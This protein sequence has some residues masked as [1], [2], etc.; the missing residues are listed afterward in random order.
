MDES[1]PQGNA[2]QKENVVKDTL[3]LFT[4]IGIGLFVIV[5]VIL[6]L[7]YFQII[8]L[9]RVSSLFSFIP[10]KRFVIANVNGESIF[11]DEVDH[12]IGLFTYFGKNKKSSEIKKDAIQFVI[13]RRLL[14][15]YV[16]E[17]NID[18]SSTV[19]K[20]Y[21]AS[22]FQY[23]NAA[24]LERVFN[25]DANTYKNYLTYNALQEKLSSSI[26]QWRIVD[27]L[28]VHYKWDESEGTKE[29]EEYKKTA[30]K[31]IKQYYSDLTSG[32]PIRTLVKQRCKDPEINYLPFQ[33]HYKLYEKTF[34]G[35]VCQ[36]QRVNF[37]VSKDTN[38]EWGNEWLEKVMRYHKGEI[39]QIITIDKPV[40]LY[41]L[42]KILDEGGNI[43][44]FDNL[45]STLKSKYNVSVLNYEYKNLY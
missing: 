30:L 12:A 1:A 38:P 28:S 16:Q 24:N 42:I 11:N 27:Y 23:T 44:S 13:N 8:N 39:S 37:T 29:G 7:N 36:E 25:T 26:I 40:G 32:V 43:S 35:T 3:Y 45:L 6:L 5:I 19:A 9:R 41:F 34:D 14:Q 31:K 15:K 2:A 18:V 17:Q 33:D 22:L 21:N 10:Q 4:G 20:R